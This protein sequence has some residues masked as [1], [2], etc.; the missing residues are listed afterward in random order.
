VGVDR[1]ADRDLVVA[2]ADQALADDEP[3]DPP[4]L[5]EAELVETVGE[6][7]DESSRVIR[8]L[9]VDLGVS[10][11]DAAMSVMSVW[12]TVNTGP[13]RNPAVALAACGAGGTGDCSRTGVI[14]RAACAVSRTEQGWAGT[15]ADLPSSGLGEDRR[16]PNGP[17]CIVRTAACF[18]ARALRRRTDQGCDRVR[19]RNSAH[20]PA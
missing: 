10:R 11:V 9:D 1:V 8:E 19:L 14:V 7:A 17:A 20:E 2:F 18:P 13:T 12:T 6:A 16:L 5:V 4:L 15:V 3:Q